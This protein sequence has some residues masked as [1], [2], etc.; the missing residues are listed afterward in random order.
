[1]GF[2][3]FTEFGVCIMLLNCLDVRGGFSFEYDLCLGCNL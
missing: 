3:Y 2:E 1:M